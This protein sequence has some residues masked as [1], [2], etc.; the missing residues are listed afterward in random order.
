MPEKPPFPG[1]QAQ[2]PGKTLLKYSPNGRRLIVAGCSNFARSFNTGDLG[3]P[4][5]I[6][7]VHED[8]LAVAAGVRVPEVLYVAMLTGAQND[9]FLLGCEDGTVCQYDIAK[10]ELDKMLVRCSLP[11]RDLA[12]SPNEEWVAVSSE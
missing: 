12:L 1:R 6:E 9:Y 3:E 10:K 8:T 7:D 2:T 5:M 4:D 11:I